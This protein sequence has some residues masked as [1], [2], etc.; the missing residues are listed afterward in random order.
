MK[1]KFNILCAFIVIAIIA[2]MTTIGGAIGKEDVQDFK[3]G[4]EQGWESAR[5][6]EAKYTQKWQYIDVIPVDSVARGVVYDARTGQA[7][8]T[9]VSSTHMTVK[10]DTQS[11]TAETIGLIGTGLAELFI[12]FFWVWFV[13]FIFLVNKGVFNNDQVKRIRWMGWFAIAVYPAKWLAVGVPQMML[14]RSV[15][16]EGYEI[17]QYMPSVMWLIIGFALLMFSLIMKM[18]QEMKQEQDLTI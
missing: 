4:Y 16:L 13:R 5:E 15:S 14:R 6:G 18:G 9:K 17:V 10:L 7:Y 3:D 8:E 11:K 12:I 1:T 2:G